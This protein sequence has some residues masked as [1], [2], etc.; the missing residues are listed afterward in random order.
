M[1]YLLILVSLFATSNAFLKQL[2][3]NSID[4]NVPTGLKSDF[5]LG[6][7]TRTWDDILF[8]GTKTL[9]LSGP[10]LLG[11][12]VHKYTITGDKLQFDFG[13]GHPGGLEFQ[14]NPSCNGYAVRNSDLSVTQF[15]NGNTGAV[16]QTITGPCDSFIINTDVEIDCFTSATNDA[17]RYRNSVEEFR[18]SFGLSIREGTNVNDVF[19]FRTGSTERNSGEDFFLMNLEVGP[20]DIIIFNWA[21]DTFR[22]GRQNEDVSHSL[23][24]DGVQVFR[25]AVTRSN[26]KKF[27]HEIG[28]NEA[29]TYQ[30]RSKCENGSEDCDFDN[31]G[32]RYGFTYKFRPNA[33]FG[34]TGQTKKMISNSRVMTCPGYDFQEGFLTNRNTNNFVLFDSNIT[35]RDHKHPA[36]NEGSGVSES[37]PLVGEQFAVAKGSKIYAT[38][39]DTSSGTI[40]IK[41]YSLLTNV[42]ERR[43]GFVYDTGVTNVDDI[44]LATDSDSDSDI[45]YVVNKINTTSTTIKVLQ[46]MSNTQ[47]ELVNILQSDVAGLVHGFGAKFKTGSFVVSVDGQ[48]ITG[49]VSEAAGSGEEIPFTKSG[50]LFSKFPKNLIPDTFTDY[51]NFPAITSLRESERA[52]NIEE[53]IKKYIRDS[54][55]KGYITQPQTA[56]DVTVDKAISQFKARGSDP[57]LLGPLTETPGSDFYEVLPTLT[58]F[59]DYED[60]P[61][62]CIPNK[63]YCLYE[64]SNEAEARDLCFQISRCEGYVGTCMIEARSYSSCTESTT[65]FYNKKKYRHRVFE[66]IDDNPWPFIGASAAI[67]IMHLGF[68]FRFHWYL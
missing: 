20:E 43:T 50:K 57:K 33:D 42:L 16:S 29:G 27:F 52:M 17:V 36:V 6:L 1:K 63:K 56:N 39:K 60:D 24:K 2:E 11:L 22:F 32:V 37:E 54:F 66:Y 64:A 15:E 58:H 3:L 13:R 49:F 68:V 9:Y 59:F 26:N 55:I 44:I 30:M 4:I 31:D 48:N 67:A 40:N 18:K 14:Y 34:C 21:A 7:P 25:S 65:E 28:P 12:I 45:I 51:I 62:T 46:P 61:R 19:N 8:C 38:Q 23:K 5:E 10:S 41:L 35:Y 53:L 47:T